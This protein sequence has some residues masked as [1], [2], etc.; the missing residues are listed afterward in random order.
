MADEPTTK[1]P[2]KGRTFNFNLTGDDL[3]LF[4]RVRDLCLAELSNED[5]TVNAALEGLDP[6]VRALLQA[7]MGAQPTKKELSQRQIFT[8]ALQDALDC[9]A[10]EPEVDLSEVI[11]PAGALE[12]EPTRASPMIDETSDDGEE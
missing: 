4:E 9:Y 6:E 11:D 2:P 10:P 12:P 1:A 3:T 7:R 5:A 8:R